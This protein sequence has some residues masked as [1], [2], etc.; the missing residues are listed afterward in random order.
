MCF[1][2]KMNEGNYR[3]EEKVCRKCKSIV[4]VVFRFNSLFNKLR[5]NWKIDEYDDK[6]DG[7]NDVDEII[8]NK[9]L[10]NLSEKYGE[11]FKYLEFEML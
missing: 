8:L 10:Y 2:N 4:K 1:L 9:A 3:S 11:P 5:K 7:E 6:D